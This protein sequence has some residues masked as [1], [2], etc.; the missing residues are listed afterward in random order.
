MTTEQG[1]AKTDIKVSTSGKIENGIETGEIE[2]IHGV[3]V[4][5]TMID[6]LDETETCSMTEIEDREAEEEIVMEGS[7]DKE[8]IERR[9]HLL[10]PRRRSRLQT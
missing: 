9:V 7:V 4:G 8:E 3:R 10:H 6:R 1:N 5:A 2:A